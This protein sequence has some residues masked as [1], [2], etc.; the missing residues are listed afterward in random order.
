[1]QDTQNVYQELMLKAA[2]DD[3]FREA[4]LRDPKATLVSLFG[5]P[6]P[7][8]LNINVVE[9]TSTELTLVIPPKLS[10]VLSEEELDE[11]AGG[12]NSRLFKDI[13]FSIATVGMGCWVSLAAGKGNVGVCRNMYAD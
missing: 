11:V 5:A 6:I 9:N 7:E 8:G 12:F 13:N 3:V 4:L 2:T 10:D 1:M